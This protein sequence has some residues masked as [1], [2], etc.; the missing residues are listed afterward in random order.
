MTHRP[1]ARD[2]RGSR[3]TRTRRHGV[4]LAAA[5]LAIVSAVG[6]GSVA[7]AS[8]SAAD[9]GAVH[10]AVAAQVAADAAARDTS[11]GTG[12]TN[13]TNATDAST[14]ATVGPPAWW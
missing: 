10:D 7:P 9:D 13:A 5:S 3:S 11:R 12:T 4:R 2:Q 1:P 14:G 8:G 6:I